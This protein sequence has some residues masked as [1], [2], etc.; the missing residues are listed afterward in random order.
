MPSTA[1]IRFVRPNGDPVADEPLG[2]IGATGNVRDWLRTDQA[3]IAS[4][5]ADDKGDIFVRIGSPNAEPIRIE[6]AR[7]TAGGP[8]PVQ[9]AADK[10][11]IRMYGQLVDRSGQPAAGIGVV[12]MRS[13]DK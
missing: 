3:G 9:V 11:V 12:V 2:L 7:L 6:H 10:P 5:P 1:Q 8:V 4:I 13:Q